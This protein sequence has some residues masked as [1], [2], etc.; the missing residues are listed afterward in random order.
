MSFRPEADHQSGWPSFSRQQ[1]GIVGRILPSDAQ[2]VSGPT[3][4]QPFDTYGGFTGPSSFGSGGINLADGGSGDIVGII[5][6]ANQL[7]VPSGYVSGRTLSDTSTYHNQTFASL[8]ATPGGGRVTRPRTASGSTSKP[9]PRRCRNPPAVSCWRCLWGSS[10]C[11]P[12]RRG[13]IPPAPRVGIELPVLARHEY[14]TRERDKRA[15]RGAAR[16]WRGKLK[17]QPAR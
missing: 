10:C 2:I 4:S 3:S 1:L 11:S 15:A 12:H 9:Q 14:R 6:A 13:C 5:G 8:G 17:P 16:W 7:A